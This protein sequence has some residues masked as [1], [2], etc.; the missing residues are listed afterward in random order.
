[1]ELELTPEALEMVKGWNPM[2]TCAFV[3]DSRKN[4]AKVVA[5][6]IGFDDAKRNAR[7][8]NGCMRV[9]RMVNGKAHTI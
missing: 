4:N 7:L 1:M 6:T 8:I 5:V 2:Q 9:G 3:C